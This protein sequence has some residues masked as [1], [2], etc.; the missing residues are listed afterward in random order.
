[1]VPLWMQMPVHRMEK[2]EGMFM[3]I[4][5]RMPVEIVYWTDEDWSWIHCEELD[6]LVGGDSPAEAELQFMKVLLDKKL[7]CL[8][9][10]R[11]GSNGIPAEVIAKFRRIL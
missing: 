5:L 1:M 10:G 4:E 6:I 7:A 3:G 9:A 2:S 8:Q 11:S